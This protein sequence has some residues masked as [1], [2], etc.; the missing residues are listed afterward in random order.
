MTNQKN[1]KSRQSVRFL[2]YIKNVYN[3]ISKL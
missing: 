2:D 3:S 1:F